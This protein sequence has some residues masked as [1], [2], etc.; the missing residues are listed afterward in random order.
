M[1]HGVII[2]NCA[3][4]GIINESDLYDAIKEG[5]VARGGAGCL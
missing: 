3:R 5:K 1:K 2:I 4:G